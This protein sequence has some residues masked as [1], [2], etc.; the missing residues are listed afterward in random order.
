MT[1]TIGPMDGTTWKAWSEIQLCGGEASLRP[2]LAC[3]DLWLTL[4]GLTASP[5]GPKGGFNQP[6]AVHPPLLPT[7]PF[8]SH[9]PL[10][11]TTHDITVVV[12][13]VPQNSEMLASWQK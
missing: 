2:S 8:P 1:E 5:N 9:P 12:K 13:K 3:L 11:R 10:I 6:P 7:S 4:L